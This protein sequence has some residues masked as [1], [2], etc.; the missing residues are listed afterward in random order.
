[1]GP[2]PRS[3]TSAG[4]ADRQ[5]GGFAERYQPRLLCGPRHRVFAADRLRLDLAAAWLNASLRLEHVPRLR[6][7]APR[8]GRRGWVQS[9]EREEL[10][11][12]QTA[13]SRFFTFGDDTCIAFRP[14]NDCAPSP[15]R[16]RQ[17]LTVSVVGTPIRA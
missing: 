17:R 6:R 3:C 4:E 15:D 14:E 1:M 5:R 10:R 2:V 11:R 7:F 12:L 8:R 9:P 13:V 16:R